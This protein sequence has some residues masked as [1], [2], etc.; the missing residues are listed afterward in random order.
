MIFESKNHGFQT[1]GTLDLKRPYGEFEDF[2]IFLK[3]A[4]EINFGSKFQ[5]NF[6]KFGVQNR[7][8]INSKTRCEKK[9]GSWETF[10][11]PKE[12]PKGASVIL[13]RQQPSG[14]GLWGGVGEGK[15]RPQGLGDLGIWD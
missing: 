1:L 12:F 14:P 2:W 13:A 15:S 9:R 11:P 4:S 6:D 5:S 10:W 8:K 7:S 3:I